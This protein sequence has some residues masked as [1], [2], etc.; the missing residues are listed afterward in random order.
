MKKHRTRI[1]REYHGKENFVSGTEAIKQEKPLTKLSLLIVPLYLLLRGLKIDIEW[2]L[3]QWAI[4]LIVAVDVRSSI[5]TNALYSYK[6]FYHTPLSEKDSTITKKI[7]NR[8]IVTALHIH[9]IIVGLLYSHSIIWGMFWY[10]LLNFSVWFVE[11]L[12]LYLKK[13]ISMAIIMVGILI[14]LFIIP[15]PTLFEWLIPMLFI[16]NV[17]TRLQESTLLKH[18]LIK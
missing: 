1:N 9:P 15:P 16:K 10:S 13:S 6:L 17:Y 12:P 5:I 4:A 11:R 2:N 7:K 3:L 8:T 18:T 14:N